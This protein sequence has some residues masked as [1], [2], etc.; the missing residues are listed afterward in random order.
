VV[1]VDR[2]PFSDAFFPLKERELKEKEELARMV[3]EQYQEFE[4]RQKK[5][6]VE[7]TA[8]DSFKRQME[9]TK[10]GMVGVI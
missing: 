3:R 8:F 9:E 7:S 5:A 1:L 4:M 2:L 10:V 6:V